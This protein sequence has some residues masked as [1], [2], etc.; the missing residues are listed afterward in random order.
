MLFHYLLL[1]FNCNKFH[2]KLARKHLFRAN[3]SL[4]QYFRT[5]LHNELLIFFQAH[6]K[7]LNMIYSI[8]FYKK[9]HSSKFSIEADIP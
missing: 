5:R 9:L 7:N 6:D 3:T 1:Q 8:N 4:T 2:S